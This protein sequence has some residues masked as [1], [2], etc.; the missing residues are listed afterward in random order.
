MEKMK[1]FSRQVKWWQN[2]FMF[3]LRRFWLSIAT[4]FGIR[5]S[6]LKKLRHDVQSCE[7]E[8]IRVMWEMLNRNESL[9]EFGANSPNKIKKMQYLKLFKWAR[10]AAPYTSHS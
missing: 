9:S 6:G 5:K 7:Y 3:P 2:N 8:D 10:C 4:R 1:K